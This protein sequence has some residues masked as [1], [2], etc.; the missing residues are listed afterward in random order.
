VYQHIGCKNDRR[1][2]KCLN[3]ESE[4]FESL[5]SAA[6]KSA[7]WSHPKFYLSTLQQQERSA[8]SSCL[9]Y[10]ALRE[11]FF[12]AEQL[13]VR[14]YCKIG[15]LIIISVF[16]DVIRHICNC[17]E[18][19]VSFLASVAL[20][21]F[22]FYASF[23]TTAYLSPLIDSRIARWHVPK[24]PCCSGYTVHSSV[25][26]DSHGRIKRSTAAKNAFRRE[27]LECG[28]ADA[29]SNMQWGSQEKTR[30]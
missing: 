12:N 26:R 1:R 18:Q 28:G 22:N 3:L 19:R 21:S 29:P 24:E 27:P 16:A 8:F 17:K 20:D 25:Q 11:W 4:L 6:R 23:L 14:R 13:G 5:F 9:S 10:K 15:C 7:N 2:V 30:S